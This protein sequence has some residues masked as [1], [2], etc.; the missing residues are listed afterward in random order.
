MDKSIY[1]QCDIEYS[2]TRKVCERLEAATHLL[3][4]S[5]VA[6][7]LGTSISTLAKW[8]SSRLVPLP[9]VKI[10]AR[11]FYRATDVEGFIAARVVDPAK[12]GE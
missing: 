9:Y 1:K 11:V 8:R 5:E 3:T 6:V 4:P 7:H 2:R 10:S 12:G